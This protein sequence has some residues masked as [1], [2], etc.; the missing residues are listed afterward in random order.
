LAEKSAIASISQ[1][2]E[3][4]FKTPQLPAL[5]AEVTAQAP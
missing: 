5:R 2:E 4:H 1:A 3:R